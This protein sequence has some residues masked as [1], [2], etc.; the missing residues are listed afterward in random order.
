MFWDQD[1]QYCFDWNTV[2]AAMI[3]KILQ[4]LYKSLV[5]RRLAVVE[6]YQTISELLKSSLPINTVR[7]HRISLKKNR[8]YVGGFYYW[9][10]D[11]AGKKSI[12]IVFQH[13]VDTTQL[14][15]TKTRVQKIIEIISDTILHEIIHMR[16]YRKRN[17]KTV[18]ALMES[19][20]TTTARQRYYSHP[21]EIDAHAFN[22]ACEFVRKYQSVEQIKSLIRSPV[23][24][25]KSNI[26]NQYLLEFNHDLKHTVIIEFIRH[27][28][29]YLPY[30]VIGKPYRRAPEL[31]SS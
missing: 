27:I 13:N 5:S 30:A 26:F 31:K 14:C 11:Q 8:L 20:K 25:T 19:E 29:R 1:M 28:N 7:H 21:D 24:K 15:M 2:D 10:L 3:A 12:T 4:P 18:A 6:I 16:Q 17:F 23:K 9:H 22:A